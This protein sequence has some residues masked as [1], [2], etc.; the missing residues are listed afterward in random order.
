MHFFY[1]LPQKVGASRLGTVT[2]GSRATRGPSS[3]A[4]TRRPRGVEIFPVPIVD[5]LQCTVSFVHPMYSLL[6]LPVDAAQDARWT[7]RLSIASL[8]V[9]LE[10]NFSPLFPKRPWP[11]LL[12]G[13]P[14]SYVDPLAF[15][16][17]SAH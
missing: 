9:E 8:A 16:E 6:N 10:R 13:T 7:K 2:D 14:L 4:S 11:F 17:C 5:R 15:L 1:G 3:R 12:S